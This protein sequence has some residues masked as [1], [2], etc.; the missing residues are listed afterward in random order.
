M[1]AAG[2]HSQ[3]IETI[4][5]HGGSL[6]LE[7]GRRGGDAAAAWMQRE[8]EAGLN[9]PH[10]LKPLAHRVAHLRHT[11][12]DRL[13]RARK[14]GARVAAYGAAAKGVV[15][16][17]TCGIGATE[18]DFV[19]DRNVHKQ[20]LHMPGTHQPIKD[21]SAL[22]D[23]MPDYVLLLAWNFKNEIMAQQAEYI[24]RGGK[25]IVP[26]PTPKIVD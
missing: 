11:L 19:V 3:R 22:L 12:P 5:L 21:V 1:R 10:A 9:T 23:E 8:R 15:M 25:F 17:E 2:L 6:R 24:E 16:L 4:P 20:G 14:E 13:A 7:A 26:V 18:L